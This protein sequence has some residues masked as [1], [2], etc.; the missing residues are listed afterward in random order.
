[1]KKNT[2]LLN[3][4]KKSPRVCRQTFSLIVSSDYPQFVSWTY[5]IF[6]L[7]G[8]LIPP[9]GQLLQQPVKKDRKG[10]GKREVNR[11]PTKKV[12]DPKSSV[13]HRELVEI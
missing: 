8:P 7:T 6:R 9:C 4:Y 11:F 12:M 3:I 2:S 13:G 5:L 10:G 1:M